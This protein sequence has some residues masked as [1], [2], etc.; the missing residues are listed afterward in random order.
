MFKERIYNFSAGPSMLPAAVLERA[1]ADL[2]N[3]NAT[4]MSVMEMS[5]RSKVYDEIFQSVKEKLRKVMNIPSGYHILFMH[6]GATGAFASVAMNLIGENGKADYVITGNFSK[7]AA[8]E[9]KKYGAVNIAY[10]TADKNHTYIPE[11]K[12]LK[13]TQG[14]SYLHYCANNTIFGT[15]WKYVPTAGGVPVVSDMSSCILSEPVDVSKFGLIYAGAQKNMAP[16]GFAVAILNKDVPI[17]TLGYTP[18]ILDYNMMIKEDSMPNTP[19]TYNIYILGLVLDWIQEL[20]G[21]TK[22]AEINR[23]KAKILYNYLDSSE[24]YISPA[25]KEARSVMNITFKTANEEMDAKFV[26]ESAAAGLANL[27]G[28]RLVG[29]MRA[30]VYNAMPMEGVAKLVE[31]MDKFERD[32]R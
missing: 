11:Q 18:K 24:F 31:F 7:N 29:G 28:H 22:M 25:Q 30:S 16:A 32:N 23:D 5:H 15:A 19:S 12:D 26:K 1:S 8:S 14:A 9:A 13:L 21:L 27:K 6:G 2:L 10:D 17:K 20:G 3:Y 4:G